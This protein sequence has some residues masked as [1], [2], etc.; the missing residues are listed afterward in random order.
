M[1]GRPR[2]VPSSP[3]PSLDSGRVAVPHLNRDPIQSLQPWPVAITCCRRELEIPALSA[4]E[5]LTVLLPED[6][7]LDD[8]FPGLL[9]SRDVDWV[10]DR[11]LQGELGV[12]EFRDLAL[13][14]IEVVS[15][16]HWWITLRLIGI[17]R[18]AWDSLG[19]DMMMRGVDVRTLSL[20]AWL[21]ILLITILRNTDPK[22]VTMFT[23]RLEA[24]PPEV[25]APVEE[26]EM[27]QSAFL[28]LGSD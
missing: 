11:L 3:A 14:V 4:G 19:P 20:S 13:G 26:M 8:I 23:M 6:M 27:S 25:E 17:A 5:W 1:V 7:Q 9:E 10:E 12:Q 24:P 16:R 15:A 21:D 28:A 22:D 18:E 2:S